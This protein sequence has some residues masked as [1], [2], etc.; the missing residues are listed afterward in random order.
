MDESGNN[1]I[2]K[3]LEQVGGGNHRQYRE[4]KGQVVVMGAKA[5][6]I[7]RQKGISTYAEERRTAV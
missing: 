1:L 6:R 2:E 3:G 5:E 4:K 7:P